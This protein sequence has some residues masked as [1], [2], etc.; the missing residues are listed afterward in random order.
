LQRSQVQALYRPPL[1]SDGQE[2]RLSRQNYGL[3][4]DARFNRALFASTHISQHVPVTQ[5]RPP[6]SGTSQ[7]ELLR[8][9]LRKMPNDGSARFALAQM[10]SQ[11]PPSEELFHVIERSSKAR[12]G[13]G[14]GTRGY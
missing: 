13:R 3:P 4:L 8:Q 10:L 1:I 14:I 2:I 12:R 7:I 6:V 5:Q 9:H 11:G